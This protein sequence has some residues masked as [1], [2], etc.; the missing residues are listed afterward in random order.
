MEDF[1]KEKI[2]SF[3]FLEIEDIEQS[4]ASV[5]IKLLRGKHIQHDEHR[6]FS[7]LDEYEHHF[8]FYY[9]RLYGLELKRK[10]SH[11]VHYFYLDFT[12][13]TKGK[14]YLT[15]FHHFLTE[16]QTIL[17]LLFLNM[18]YSSYFSFEKEFSWEDIKSEIKNGENNHLYQS[19]LFRKRSESGDYTDGQ[20][21]DVK[22]SFGNTIRS[23]EKLGWCEIKR[24]AEKN[25]IRF[26]IKESIERFIEMYKDELTHFEVFSEKIKKMRNHEED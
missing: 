8:K 9:E 15:D 19:Y 12:E 7:I 10:I 25:E 1:D 18:Y 21:S 11:G 23:L 5:N 22:K 20:W 4:F 16:H 13:E 17:A 14:L 26:T 6:T 24:G 2:E 3:N